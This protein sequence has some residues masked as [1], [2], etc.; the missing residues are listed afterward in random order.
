MSFQVANA[1]VLIFASSKS[2]AIPTLTRT[3][4]AATAPSLATYRF[5]CQVVIVLGDFDRAVAA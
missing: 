3:V 4:A 1:C 2:S 5:G